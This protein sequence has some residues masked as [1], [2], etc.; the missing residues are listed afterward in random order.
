MFQAID[1]L[2]LHLGATSLWELLTQKRPLL[3]LTRYVD[4][5]RDEPSLCH[6]VA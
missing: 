1:T 2:L 6:N 3:F 5:P 4:H